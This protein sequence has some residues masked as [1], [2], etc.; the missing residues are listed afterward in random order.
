LSALLLTAL[1]L[2]WSGI[3]ATAVTGL[4]A[5]P[6]FGEKPAAIALNG[7]PQAS[8]GALLLGLAVYPLCYALGFATLGEASL[9]TGA[10]LGTAHAA[11]L[12][13]LALRR[14]GRKRLHATRARMLLCVLYGAMLGFAFVTP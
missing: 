13:L 6:F 8:G 1:L 10:L 11:V 12:G 2:L 4:V 9:A 3:A 14:G 7:Q 5:A